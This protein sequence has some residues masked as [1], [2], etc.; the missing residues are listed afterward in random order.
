[1]RCR[2]WIAAG[3]VALGLSA[4]PMIRTTLADDDEHVQKHSHKRPKST[5][6]TPHDFVQ[7]GYPHEV[8][9]IA[10]ESYNE[11]YSG[12][13]IG[14]GSLFGGHGGC[15]HVG[16]WGWDYTPFHKRIFLNWSDGRRYQG[17]MGAYK[18]DGPKPLEHLT[19][20]IHSHFGGGE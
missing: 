5:E 7:A 15:A 16:T 14:G 8:S 1:M 19:E 11:H 17:G 6:A 3:L 20:K 13:Y 9:Q 18:T 10:M 4:N 2:S 12:G